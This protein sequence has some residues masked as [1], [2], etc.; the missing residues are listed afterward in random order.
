MVK[1]EVKLKIK[2]LSEN[3]REF[4]WEGETVR[5]SREFPVLLIN[6]EDEIEVFETIKRVSEGTLEIVS[7]CPADKG[8]EKYVMLQMELASRIIE[9]LSI[10]GLM[11]EQGIGISSN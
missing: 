8:V 7:I 4:R 10:L 3:H 2:S 5:S 6:S 9:P 11:E 1:Y